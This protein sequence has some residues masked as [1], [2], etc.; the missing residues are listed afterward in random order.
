MTNE[1]SIW[2][3]TPPSEQKRRYWVRNRDSETEEPGWLE[4]GAWNFAWPFEDWFPNAYPEQFQ[5]GPRVLTAEETVELT[6][7]VE[8]LRQ[9]KE[10]AMLVLAEWNRVWEALGK[11]GPLG[12]SNAVESK[13][14]V[15]RLRAEIAELR[16]RLKPKTVVIEDMKF[17]PIPEEE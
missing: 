5:F 7:E 2:S 9:W 6:A 12:S 11:P 4:D 16:E 1:P 14:E 15:E 3:D 17:L 13:R 10:S 8:R